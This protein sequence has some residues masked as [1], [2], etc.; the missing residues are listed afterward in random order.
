MIR[1]SQLS[2]RAVV[3]IEAAEKLG[4]IDKVIVDPDARRVAAYVLTRGGAFSGERGEMV[5]P[6]TS[7]HAIGPD[8][9]TVR[10]TE[11]AP[12]PCARALLLAS[13]VGWPDVL[14]HHKE[15]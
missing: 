5:L 14:T 10:N 3:D 12:G 11:A 6:A 7:V 15:T 4:Q 2:G 1:A 9:V 8:A 13:I